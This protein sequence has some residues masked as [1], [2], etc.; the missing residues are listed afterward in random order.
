MLYF[1]Q[2]NNID[3]YHKSKMQFMMDWTKFIET[4]SKWNKYWAELQ[5]EDI[6]DLNQ[7]YNIL[8][9]MSIIGLSRILSIKI[10][11]TII[12]KIIIAN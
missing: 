2:Q 10:I 7:Q 6:A 11:K 1:M 5:K 12:I 9:M 8:L 3:I 4:V